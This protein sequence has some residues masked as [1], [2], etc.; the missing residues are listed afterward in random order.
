M[1]KLKL[2]A[3]SYDVTIYVLS[4]DEIVMEGKV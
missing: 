4:E 1:L 2:T 3:Y